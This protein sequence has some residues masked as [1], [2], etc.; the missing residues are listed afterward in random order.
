MNFL[1]LT[2]Q[3]SILG[4]V[5]AAVVFGFGLGVR[6]SWQTA[7]VAAAIAFL[8]WLVVGPAWVSKSGMVMGS[9]ITVVGFL[10]IYPLFMIFFASF[11]GGPPGEPSP[12]TLRGYAEAYS[13]KETY[14][15]LGVTMWLGAVRAVL[16]V[17]LAVALAWVVTRTDTPWRGGLEVLIWLKFFLP[18]LPITMSWV[19]LGAPKT[20]L[21]NQA[22][23]KL[24]GTE[25]SPFNIYSFGGIIWVS[26]ISWAAVLFILIVPAFRGMDA[27]LEES[28]RM[29][30]AGG[31]T[32][33]WRITIPILMPAILGALLLAFIRL[34]E[35]FETELLL[36][37]T[38]GLY[39]Y[40]TRVWLL[41]SIVPSDYPQ[42]MALTAI[43]LLLVGGLV[44]LQWWLLGR[45]GGHAAYVTVTGRGFATRP[46]RLGKLRWVAFGLVV[47]YFVIAA[48]LPLL[49]LVMGSFMKLFGVFLE[50]PFTV[51]H[52]RGAFAD[53]RLFNSFK[54]TMIVGM[55]SATGG[56]I[57]Y[58]FMSYIISRTKFAG[59]HA[60]DF[61]AWLPWAVPG[62]VMA[63]GFLWAYVGG[64][65]LPFTLYGTIYLMMLVFVVRGFPLGVRVMNGAMVQLG[66]ELEESSRVL[67]A[68]W[69]YTFRRVI[70]P[71]LTPSFIGAWI[72]TFVIAVRDL[73]TVIMLY[74]AKSRLLAILTFEYWWGNQ[75]E[76]GMVIGLLLAIITLGLALLARWVGR[77]T[78]VQAG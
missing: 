36:G 38:Q 61:I 21:M 22:F 52:W 77:K 28:S 69:F 73:V 53:P 65:K 14:T 15:T 72:I 47:G 70:A 24:T 41:L 6:L 57:L 34:M 1:K 9:L 23:M 49:T 56:M 76:R 33:T 10:V 31:R 43:F 32:T 78:E 63:L 26:V 54:N 25:I 13:T 58:S 3:K 48:V 62:M 37:F 27:S 5:I 46:T 59:R 8:V 44:A 68:S 71:L 18:P 39:V 16:A 12:F 17:G 60:L 67:G 45:R 4:L 30:G 75:P 29:S 42:A 55:V 7:A 2:T 11:K 40:T 19:L 51:K 50:E 20:G 66:G 35:S 74:G 64:I